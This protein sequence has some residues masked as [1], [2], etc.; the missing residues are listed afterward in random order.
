[1]EVFQFQLCTSSLLNI[2][3]VTALISLSSYEAI[4]KPDY[5]ELSTEDSNGK[6]KNKKLPG[7]ETRS[8]AYRKVTYLTM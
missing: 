4:I 2:S 3:H 6:K 5:L 1:V 7:K 8:S